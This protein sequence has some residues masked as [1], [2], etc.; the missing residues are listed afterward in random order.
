MKDIMIIAMSV[1]SAVLNRV[2][3]HWVYLSR[4]FYSIDAEEKGIEMRVEKFVQ[5][6]DAYKH[7]LFLI[8]NGTI[9]ASGKNNLVL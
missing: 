9:H 4:I 1:C 8:P 2:Y 3:V 7:D 5:M 6:H